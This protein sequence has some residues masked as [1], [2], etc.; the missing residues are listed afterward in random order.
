LPMPLKSRIAARGQ[1]IFMDRAGGKC[2]ACHFNAGANVDPSIFGQNAGTT[3]WAWSHPAR[4]D[5][6]SRPAWL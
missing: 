3:Q 2:N 6:V 1:A 5:D 4:A